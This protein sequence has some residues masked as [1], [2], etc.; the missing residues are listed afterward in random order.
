MSQNGIYR[1]SLLPNV[2]QATISKRLGVAWFWDILKFF[3]GRDGRLGKHTLLICPSHHL[4]VW[5]ILGD[6]EQ[7][8]LDY[9]GQLGLCHGNL[10]LLKSWFVRLS[11]LCQDWQWLHFFWSLP[12]KNRFKIIIHRHQ[13]YCLHFLR[14]WRAIRVKVRTSRWP[15]HWKMVSGCFVYRS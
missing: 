9:P 11:V 1:N 2:P 14:S 12:G 15:Y 13:H 6:M 3:S 10:F 4:S 7:R 8:T 5:L